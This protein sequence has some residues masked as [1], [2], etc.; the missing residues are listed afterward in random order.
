ML[1]ITSKI[2]DDTLYLF[3]TVDS[4][5]YRRHKITIETVTNENL[6]KTNSSFLDFWAKKY[7][8]KIS[9]LSQEESTLP[10]GQARVTRTVTVV[11]TID[12]MFDLL[13]LDLVPLGLIFFFVIRKIVSSRNKI[14][15]EQVNCRNSVLSYTKIMSSNNNEPIQNNVSWL[16]PTRN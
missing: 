6:K 15:F 8:R 13:P 10:S 5:V 1:E 3:I 9:T 16:L 14:H 4:P 2:P 11:K 7:K 12:L